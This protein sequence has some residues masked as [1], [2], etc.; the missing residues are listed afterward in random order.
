VSTPGGELE[1]A[2]RRIALLRELLAT[3]GGEFQITQDGETGV[4]TAVRRPT[5]TA[6]EV[7]VAHTVDELASKLAAA[8]EPPR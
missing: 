5:P 8:Q 1:E 2:Q 7:I 3:Y 6:Q 4:W